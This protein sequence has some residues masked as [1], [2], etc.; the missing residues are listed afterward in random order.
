MSQHV[1]SETLWYHIHKT[2]LA[3]SVTP[4][5]DVTL[6]NLVELMLLIPIEVR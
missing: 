5:L 1:R 3:N 6:S 2:I 4:V